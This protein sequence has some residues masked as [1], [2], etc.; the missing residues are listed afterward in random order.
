MRINKNFGLPG[1]ENQL[2]GSRIF[3]ICFNKIPVQVEVFAIAPKAVSHRAVLIGP[4]STC[5]VKTTVD[6][7]K[8][9]DT[10]HHIFWQLLSFN[11]IARQHH[12]SVYSLWLARVNT[13]ID[14]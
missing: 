8:R 3:R 14:Q 5:T 12:R 10:N 1:I 13:V 7:V 2:K 9:N 11:Q 6:V 4:R